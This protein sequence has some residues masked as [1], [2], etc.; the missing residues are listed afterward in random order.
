MIVSV[1]SDKGSPGVSTLAAALGVVWPGQRVVLDADTAGGDLPFRLWTAGPAG[2]AVRLSPSPSIAQLATAAR[3]G[4]S[5][6]GPLPFAQSTSLGVPVVPGALSADRFSSLRSL[7][8]QL[9]GELAA[10]PGTV[11]ADLGRLQPDNP[12]LPV[13]RASTAVLLVTR[14]DLESLAHLRDRVAELTGSLGDPGRDRGPVGVVATGPAKRRQFNSDQV[15]QVLASIGSPAPVVGYLAHDPAGAQG[16]WAGQ[17]NRRFAG[18]D[19][20]RSVRAVAGSALATW[21]SLI[22]ATSAADSTAS[23][24][25]EPMSPAPGRSQLDDGPVPADART[26]M[27]EARP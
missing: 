14:V 27:Q 6:A 24:A 15:R 23:V 16:L 12:V 7:W 9:A 22:P 2:G 1:C 5:A 19:L 4:L 10:W 3:L 8:P 13:A 20:L 25:A 26:E 17:L 18:S 11:I 21:P